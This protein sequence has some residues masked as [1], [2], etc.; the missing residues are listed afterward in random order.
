[1]LCASGRLSPYVSLTYMKY[2]FQIGL[3]KMHI[4][5]EVGNADQFRHCVSSLGELSCPESLKRVRV[6]YVFYTAKKA[7]LYRAV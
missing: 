6:R 2:F 1:M 5:A 4:V 3:V 7:Q